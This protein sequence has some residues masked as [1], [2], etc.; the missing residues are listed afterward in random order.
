MRRQN[1]GGLQACRTERRLGDWCLL[2]RSQGGRFICCGCAG[3]EI[4]SWQLRKRYV[5]ER[6]VPLWRK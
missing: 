4:V 5:L 6:G 1:G 2:R 3:S